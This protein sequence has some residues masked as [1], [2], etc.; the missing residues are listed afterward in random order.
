MTFNLAE[1][2]VWKQSLLAVYPAQAVTDIGQLQWQEHNSQFVTL[3]FAESNRSEFLLQAHHGQYYFISD[4]SGLPQIWRSQGQNTQQISQFKTQLSIQQLLW[5]NDKLLLLVDRQ[6]FEFS[7]TSSKLIPFTEKLAGSEHFVVCDNTLYWT[8]KDQ[9]GWALNRLE[10][11]KNKELLRDVVNVGC[12]PGQ[13]LVL[14]QQDSLYVRQ[15]LQGQTITLPIQINW[16]NTD[17]SAWASTDTGLYWLSANG[18]VLNYY[19]WVNRQHQQWPLPE[20]AQALVSG[21]DGTLFVQQFRAQ[22]TDI[23]WLHPEPVE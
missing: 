1:S 21:L 4:R 7:E 6:L 2:S 18:T 19:G 15:W 12:G 16:R 14:Q 11:G 10:Q 22:D 3:P 20:H 13:S 5:F 8:S 9:K 17:A 23:V